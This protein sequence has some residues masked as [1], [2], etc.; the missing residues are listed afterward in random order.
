MTMTSDIVE[1]R[2]FQFAPFGIAV[3]DSITGI[4]SD[5][6]DACCSILG[7]DKTEVLGSCWMAFTH[8]DDIAGDISS[9]E[10]LSRDKREQVYRKKRYIRPD[11]TVVHVGLTISA[12][13]TD[14]GG[15][16]YVS[17]IENLTPALDLQSRLREQT[18]ETWRARESVFNSMAILSEFRDRETGEHIL[19]SKT[20]V[21]L[22]LENLPF[23]HPFSKKA[24]TLISNSAMLHDIGKVGIPDSILLKPG[25]L[26]PAEF[27]I[28]KTHTT[29]GTKAILHTRHTL[30]HDTVLM[31]A[32]EIAE[33]HHEWWD[34][35]GYP[36]RLKGD[37]I[38]LTARV[39]AL[40]D[41]YDALVSVRPYKGPMSHRDAVIVIEGESG[42][43]FDPVLVQLFVKL[44]KEFERVASMNRQELEKKLAEDEQWDS[45]AAIP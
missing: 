11:G 37:Q 41:V 14:T 26:T 31:F 32:Q 45:A 33:F 34:G 4:F 39:M 22:L 16:S 6:N 19:R 43:H 24:I 18:K 2:I 7:R 20:Y 35:S 12:L 1:K 10:E 40:A 15:Q 3:V 25:P 17:I 27:K 23:E 44:E 8:P 21:K 5:L 29:L 13:P 9:L 36:L 38:P 30:D 42:T 28:M